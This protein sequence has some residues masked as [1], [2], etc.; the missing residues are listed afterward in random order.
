MSIIRGTTPTVT[1]K[2]ISSLDLTEIAELWITFQKKIGA[3]VRE[4]TFTLDDVAIDLD[5]QTVTMVLTQED[6]LSFAE[7]TINVQL[8]VR[9]NDGN[10]YAS[11]I[12]ETTVEKILKDGVI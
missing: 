5:E 12:L 6:T 10:A 2:I 3:T 11:S 4:R 1:F 8:R 7:N 9:M